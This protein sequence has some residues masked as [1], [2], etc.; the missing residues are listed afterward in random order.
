VQFALAGPLPA[1]RR[2]SPAELVILV[3]LV[4]AVAGFVAGV[5]APATGAITL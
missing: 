4:I 2:F 3:I 5:V 1:R